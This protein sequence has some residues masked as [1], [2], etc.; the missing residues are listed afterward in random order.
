MSIRDDIR[1]MGYIEWMMVFA[2]LAIAVGVGAG[3]IQDAQP[4]HLICQNQAGQQTWQVP[5]CDLSK[6]QM[7]YSFMR[8]VSITSITGGG[9]LDE[10]GSTT[11]YIVVLEPIKHD[12]PV[13]GKVEDE[14]YH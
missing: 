10:R 12:Q 6:F 8:T 3:L 13:V 14:R 2:I 9:A 1:S 7:K 4:A 5:V 11:H